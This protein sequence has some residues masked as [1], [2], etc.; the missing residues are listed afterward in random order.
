MDKQ[1][2]MNLKIETLKTLFHGRNIDSQR[3]Y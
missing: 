2:Q 3:N 1:K